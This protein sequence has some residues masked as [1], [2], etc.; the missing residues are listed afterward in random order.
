MVTKGSEGEAGTV[1]VTYTVSSFDSPNDARRSA[2]L[3]GLGSAAD[4][5]L[6][7]DAPLN[8][9]LYSLP[10]NDAQSL[11]EDWQTLEH[12]FRCV[13]E[14]T[15][16]ELVRQLREKQGTLFDADTLEPHK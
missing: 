12:D 16:R 10:T 15:G 13:F 4:W 11:G 6:F 14:R 2:F 9:Y 3:D 8:L 7:G 1:T 5:D